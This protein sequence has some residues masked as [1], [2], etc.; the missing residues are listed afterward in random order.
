MTGGLVGH[1]LGYT[2]VTLCLV[3]L[4]AV[5]DLDNLI[6]VVSIKPVVGDHTPEACS[7]SDLGFP[8]GTVSGTSV[9]C[10]AVR[11]QR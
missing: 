1:R 2:W 3:Y 11:D 10:Y 5:R 9:W 6:P 4:E 7:A 8:G